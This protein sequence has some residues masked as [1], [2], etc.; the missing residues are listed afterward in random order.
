MSKPIAKSA[1]IS[2]LTKK[3]YESLSELR[4]QLGRFIRFSENAAKSK[5][6]TPLQYLLLLHVRGFPGRDSVNVGELAER[7]HMKPHGVVALLSRCEAL[8]LVERRKNDTDRRQV[9]VYLLP[10]GEHSLEHLATLHQAELRSLKNTFH[11][12]EI[13]AFNDKGEADQHLGDKQ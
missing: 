9:D 3:H 4:Y 6:L 13:A 2:R 10:A 12:A 11:V 1:S 5:G 8:E 7:L